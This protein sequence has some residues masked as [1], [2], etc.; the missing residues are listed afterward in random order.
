M[1]AQKKVELALQG[2]GAHGAFTWGVLDRFLQDER[3]RIEGISGTS[4]GA[5]NA[6]V[7]AHGMQAGGRKGAREALA[8]FWS[9]VSD[10]ARYSPLQRTLLD[11]LLGRWSLDYSPGYQLMDHLSRMVSP[12]DF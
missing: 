4:A 12:Y 6:V 11:R 9:A 10:A 5:M 2:G 1:A 3:I 7:M 8:G